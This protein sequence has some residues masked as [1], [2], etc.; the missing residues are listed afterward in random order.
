[1]NIRFRKYLLFTVLLCIVFIG[2]TQN[3][4]SQKTILKGRITDASTSEILPYV[5]ISFLNTSIGT[6]T[7]DNG[8]FYLETSINNDSILVSYVGYESQTLKIKKFKTQELDIKLVP[9]EMNLNEITVYAGEN[10]A[11]PIFRNILKNKKTNNPEKL[12]HFNCEVYNKLQV[13]LNNVTEKFKQRKAFKKFQFVFEL[14]DSSE[15]M[16]KTYLPVFLT[17]NYSNYYYQKRPK[18]KKEITV[19]SRISGIENKSYVEFTGQMYIDINLYDNYV[20]VFGQQFVSPFSNTGLLVYKYFLEDSA[21]VDNKWCYNI[22]FKPRRKQEK[23]FFGD[24]WVNDTTWAIKKVNAR[25]SA[26]ANINYVKDLIIDQ[27]Y[28]AFGDTIW[29]KTKDEMFADINL[30]DK[31]IGFFGRKQT[32]YKNLDFTEQPDDFFSSTQI[33]EAIISDTVKVNQLDQWNE[34]RPEKLTEEQEQIYDMVDSV[35]NVPLFR[36]VTDIIYLLAYGYYEYKYFEFGPYFKTYSFNPTEGSRF[37]FG[38]RTS[39]SFSKR[40]MLYGHLAYGTKDEEFKY[41]L[42][43]LYM[44]KKDPRLALDVFYENDLY[45]LGQSVNAFSEDNI[46]AS[47]LSIRPN[48]NLLPLERYSLS[49]EKEWFTG[50][51]NEIKLFHGRVLPSDTIP[52]QNSLQNQTWDDL[53]ISEVTLKT[54]FAYNEK[55]VRGEFER[56]SLGS[57]YP[58][59]DLELTAGLKGVLESDFEYYRVRLN[60]SDR[61]DIKPFG[62]LRYKIGAGKIFGQVPFPLLVLHE[63]NE[64]YAMDIHAYNLMNYY[65]FAS[66]FYQSVYLEHHFQGLFLNKIPLFRKLKWR[67]ILYAKLLRGTIS[68]ENKAKWDFPGTLGELT[69]PYVEAGVGIENIFKIIRIDAIWRLSNL[70]KPEIQTFGLRA[71]FQLIF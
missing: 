35:K 5:N 12:E 7:E 4:L 16:G 47:V 63:G 6:I 25:I 36:T 26:D 44:F 53:T 65:E 55:V 24:F 41:G 60:I 39:N 9:T 13:D 48:N 28:T 58:I 3:L 54:R 69:T 66:D 45:L 52:F 17:E 31:A 51:S 21:Y 8:T 43:A 14:E 56:V 10:P 11:H 59:I 23:T 38:G 61:I 67:E 33:E 1:V 34:L 32:I 64:T 70:N 57:V 30:A 42:G 29:F 19:A 71:K 68:D 20:N 62:Y 40:I 15:V 18:R 50:F 27:E 49:L 2:G 46:L 22:T 37:R